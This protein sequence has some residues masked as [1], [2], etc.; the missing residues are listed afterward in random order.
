MA[1]QYP[2][3]AKCRRQL[4]AA[5][6]WMVRENKVCFRWQHLETEPRELLGHPIPFCHYTGTIALEILLVL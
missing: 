3:L 4:A 2:L 1:N 6:G 5:M